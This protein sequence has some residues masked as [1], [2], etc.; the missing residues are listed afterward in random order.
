MEIVRKIRPG[1]RHATENH[2]HPGQHRQ[3][4]QQRKP[5]GVP[6]GDERAGPDDQTRRQAA[7]GQIEEALGQPGMVLEGLQGLQYFQPAPGGPV[8]LDF[9]GPENGLLVLAQSA[10]YPPRLQGGRQ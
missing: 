5:Q 3:R 6:Q 7:N 1:I 9:L 10:V 4:Q 2:R 8:A